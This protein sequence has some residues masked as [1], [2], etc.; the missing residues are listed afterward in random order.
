MEKGNYY[1]T[2][3]SLLPHKNLGTL[4]KMLAE[5]KEKSSTQLKPLVISGVGGSKGDE[6]LQLD[7]KFNVTEYIKFT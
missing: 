5:L 3:S 1:Y 2:V 6:L 7:H 4:I